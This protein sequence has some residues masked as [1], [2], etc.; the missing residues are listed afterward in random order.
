MK[1]L[2]SKLICSQKNRLDVFETLNHQ[3]FNQENQKKREFNEEYEVEIS[4]RESLLPLMNIKE[5][6]K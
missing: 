4:N 5:F 6:N 2:L 3:F 1:D